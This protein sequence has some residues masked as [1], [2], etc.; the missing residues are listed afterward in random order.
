MKGF[1]ILLLGLIFSAGFVSAQN[2]TG[3]GQSYDVDSQGGGSFAIQIS[4][5]KNF[6]NGSR[7]VPVNITILNNSHLGY[8]YGMVDS[9]Y[10]IYF[11]SNSNL[12]QPVRFEK[13][14]YF[15]VYDISQGTMTW[16]G[17]AGQ[18]SASDTLGSG[19]SSNSGDTV[20]VLD[21]SM[22]VYPNAFYNTNVSYVLSGG[23]VKE[24]F[25][26]AGVP[27]FKDYFYLQY[28]G[29]IRFNSSLKICTDVR[30]FVPSGTQDDFETSG[31]I[32]FRKANNQTVFYLKSPVIRDS[33]G[34]ITV[35][36]YS[37]HGSNAQM[38]F[39][40]RINSTWL[41][42]ATFPVFIDP[43][44][45]IDV[46]GSMVINLSDDIYNPL[47]EI[48]LNN[49][50]GEGQ[51]LV[52]T[53][54]SAG[55]R[56]AVNPLNLS[57]AYGNI[58]VK[59]ASNSR[60]LKCSLWDYFL[61][62]CGGDWIAMGSL[63]VGSF[64]GLNFSNSDPA[65]SE[66]DSDFEMATL[67][68]IEGDTNH[69]IV[70]STKILRSYIDVFESS[71]SVAYAVNNINCS[72]VL[73]NTDTGIVFASAPMLYNDFS[74]SYEYSLLITPALWNSLT[75]STMPDVTNFVGNILCTSGGLGSTTRSDQI[76]LVVVR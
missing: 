50:S 70:F 20:A 42:N 32:Y 28:S 49:V 23:M 68:Y 14:G 22:L 67:N 53:Q 7:F 59:N 36:L 12:D 25:V 17:R 45:S 10:G 21:G 1:L 44:V 76:I 6:F 56:Y 34:K 11:L 40:L 8:A 74:E 41:R 37:V 72:F 57:F 24:T 43:T 2:I 55:V 39:W 75:N 69:S 52:D 65:Y 73:N 71:N 9:Y 27:S 18:P 15:F 47:Q 54:I 60:L 61:E 46:D 35:G 16:I 62:S 29:N 26:L 48:V 31:N 64:Y 58:V 38:N 4:P 33:S 66:A 3:R 5:F 13:D 30:C 51:L 19:A 63:P